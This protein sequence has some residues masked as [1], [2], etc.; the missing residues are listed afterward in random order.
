M[1]LRVLVLIPTYTLGLISIHYRDS[2]EW[3]VSVHL[4]EGDLVYLVIGWHQRGDGVEELG[5]DTYFSFPRIITSCCKEISKGRTAFE[6]IIKLCAQEGQVFGR[7]FDM[8]FWNYF[9]LW[10]CV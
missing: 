9:L 1:C 6:S 7:L 3:E 8:L 10:I 4:L 2:S 5:N